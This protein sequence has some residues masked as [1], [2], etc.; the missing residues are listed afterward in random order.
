MSIYQEAINI[1]SPL[2][3]LEFEKIAGD[4]IADSPDGDNWCITYDWCIDH[5]GDKHSPELSKAIAK[6]VA[7]RYFAFKISDG[8]GPQ[9]LKDLFRY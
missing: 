6:D 2:V 7:D 5:L 3:Q 1:F 8:D 9:M 4:I